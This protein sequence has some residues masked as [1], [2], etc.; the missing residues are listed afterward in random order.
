M[1]KNYVFQNKISQRNGIVLHVC[2]SLS[3]CIKRTVDSPSTS[4]FNLLC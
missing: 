3:Y 4:P 2:K 1:K